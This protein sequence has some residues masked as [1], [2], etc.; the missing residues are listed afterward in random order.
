M[1][2]RNHW[3]QKDQ[4]VLII[5]NSFFKFEVWFWRVNAPGEYRT[6]FNMFLGAETSL[7]IKFGRMR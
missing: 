7:S 1:K 2:V 5:E 6:G 3:D 4:R